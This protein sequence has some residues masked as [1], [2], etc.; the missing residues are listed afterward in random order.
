MA[1]GRVGHEGLNRWRRRGGWAAGILLAT[2]AP[3]APAGAQ[4]PSGG[5][6][7]D[8]P[9]PQTVT[10]KSSPR[11]ILQDQAVISTSPAR[12]RLHD[13]VWLAPLA[14]VTTAAVLTDHQVM[15]NV[16]NS[17]SFK[18]DSINV[19]NV[20]IGSE[21]A[22]PAVVFGY[23]HLEQDE[24]ARVAGILSGEA[25]LDGV[26]VEQGMKLIFWRERPGPNSQERFFQSDAGVD[27]AFPSSHSVLA[28]AAASELAGEYPAVWQ[29]AAL[30]STA[31][32]IS[33]TRVLGQ[34]HSPGDVVAGAAAGWLVGRY[35]FRAH[36]RRRDLP[37]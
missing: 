12:I 15:K 11:H 22:V 34:Q 36:H 9:E 37:N 20:L 29:Q 16:S 26:V 19:S 32:A 10:L 4:N 35:V 7:P 18:Q 33:L 14:G 28:F 25:V 3:G 21:L 27:S 1:H 31:T 24:H 8:A 23:G 2:L 30:Y 6:L 5:A 17:A 13:L